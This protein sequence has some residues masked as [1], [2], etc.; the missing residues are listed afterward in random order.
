MY[1]ELALIIIILCLR[2]AISPN[3]GLIF[4]HV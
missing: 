3:L 4:F 2:E 1:F